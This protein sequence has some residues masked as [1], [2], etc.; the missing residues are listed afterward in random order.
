MQKTLARYRAALCALALGAGGAAAGIPPAA[1]A[2]SA[3][4][5]MYHRFGESAYPATNTTIEQLE[6]HIAELTSGRYALR[7]LPEI[8]AALRKGEPLPEN[9]VGISVDDAY[10]SLYAEG[11]PRLRAAGIPF[12]LFV[13]TDEIDRNA[14][15]FMS[16]DQIRELAQAGVTIGSQ[17]ASHP[18]MAAESRERNA[19]ELA[20]SNARFVAELGA[21]PTLIAYPYG[22][23]SLE[24]GEVAREAGFEAG[25]GQHSGVLHPGEDFFFL[26]RF[27]L[28][29]VYGDLKR[30]RLAAR[31]LPLPVTDITPPDPK[32]SPETNPP[33]FGFTVTGEAVKGIP[34]LACYYSAEGKL[35]VER[36]GETRVEV[37][38]ENAF[39]AGRSRINCT[40]PAHDGRWR[41]FGRQFYVTP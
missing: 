22:E 32:L 14:P 8:V 16:W 6:E 13:A 5:F 15:G 19:A 36:L 28:N 39:P 11:W 30:I 9:T 40:M 2:E 37:R 26:P 20:K 38:T 34:Q 31:A 33:P 3:V 27:A 1:A 29:E 10:A 12:T 23:Y 35:H 21:A 25:F 41:W 7:P 18:H 17:T 4:V 24:V